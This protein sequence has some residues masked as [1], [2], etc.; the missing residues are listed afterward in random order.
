MRTGAK[1]QLRDI[2]REMLIEKIYNT[3]PLFDPT[4]IRVGSQ[5]VSQVWPTAWSAV[6]DQVLDQASLG[7]K[8]PE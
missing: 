1:R 2:S 8:G 4:T 3:H 6:F 7:R 5:V